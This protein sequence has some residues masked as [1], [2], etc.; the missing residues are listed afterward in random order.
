MAKELK[1]LV[2]WQP[3]SSPPP[4]EIW[5]DLLRVKDCNGK[6]QSAWWDGKSWKFGKNQ[7]LSTI[8]FWERF[9]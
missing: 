8:Q 4:Q 9:V 1:K 5:Y 7:G 2:G 3:V 6:T